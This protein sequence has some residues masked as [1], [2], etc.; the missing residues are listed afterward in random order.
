MTGQ[1]IEF[2]D[3]E[4]D[5]VVGAAAIR[6]APRRIGVFSDVIVGMRVFDCLPALAVTRP[7]SGSRVSFAAARPRVYGRDND[8]GECDPVVDDDCTAV[9]VPGHT[10]E[11]VDVI[12]AGPDRRVIAVRRERTSPDPDRGASEADPVTV[13]RTAAGVRVRGCGQILTWPVEG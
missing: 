4:G 12:A 6:L 3:E 1:L 9:C 7:A 5:F 2:G 10:R 8:G 13:E 11:W